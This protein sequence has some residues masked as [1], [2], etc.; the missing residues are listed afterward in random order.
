MDDV[1]SLFGAQKPKWRKSFGFFDVYLSALVDG[2]VHNRNGNI[3]RYCFVHK[4]NQKNNASRIAGTTGLSWPRG[5]DDQA[6][7]GR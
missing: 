2:S 4:I 1:I 7:A 5:G 3:L 6:K